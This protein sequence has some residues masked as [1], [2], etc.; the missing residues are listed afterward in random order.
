V[1]YNYRMIPVFFDRR[2]LF[3]TVIGIIIVVLGVQQFIFI[4]NIQ[5]V[6]TITATAKDGAIKTDSKGNLFI[7]KGEEINIVWDSK[8]AKTA[9]DSSGRIISLSGTMTDVPL[10]TTSYSYQFF[11]GTKNIT[12]I[13]SVNVVSGIIDNSSLISTSANPI[14]F[15]TATGTD[16]IKINIAKKGDSKVIYDSGSVV[17]KN[18][19]WKVGVSNN[20]PPGEYNV[21]VSSVGD[22]VINNISEGILTIKKINIEVIKPNPPVV[23]PIPKPVPVSIPTLIPAPIPVPIEIDPNAKTTIAVSLVPLLVGG[24][25]HAGGSV[26]V[27]YLQVANIGNGYASIKG[28]YIK[29]NGSASADAVIGLTTVDDRNG[30]RGSVGGVE[31]STPFKNGTAFAPVT[32]VILAPGD[33]KLFTIKV[34]MTSN[35]SSYI[36]QQLMIDVQSVDTNATVSGSFPIRGTTWT[37]AN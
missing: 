31:G 16:Y 18:G 17:V 10:D 23:V 21:M 33:M 4:S 37:I 20:L 12:C 13:V 7:L 29:Q 11:R 32:N 14:I 22:V 6:C 27:S 24:T 35:V 28:F 1:V 5:P 2:I 26:P 30:S 36:G 8:D 19:E 34:V 15:G 25:V 9:N 3:F